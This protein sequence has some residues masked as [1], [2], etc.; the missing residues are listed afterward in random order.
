MLLRM[1]EAK[2]K[3][4]R[5]CPANG[6]TITAAECGGGRNSAIA[7]PVD[8][9]HNPFNPDNHA[10]QF[11]PIEEKVFGHL[12]RKLAAGLTPSQMREA[13]ALAGSGN[14]LAL[15]AFQTWR[16]HGA[17]RLEGWMAD[18]FHRD[19]KNDERVLLECLTTMRPSLLEFREVLDGI[20]CMA[21]D[22]LE[23]GE[24][25][26]LIDVSMAARACRYDVGLGWT[27]DVPGGR[28]LCGG[29]AVPPRIGALAPEEVLRI[30]LD[31][32]DAPAGMPREWILENMTLIA[33]AFRATAVARGQAEL[34]VSD[35]RNFEL[36]F[37]VTDAVSEEIAARLSAH[38]RVFVEGTEDD[39]SSFS[40]CLLAEGMDRDRDLESE[41]IGDLSLDSGFLSVLCQG[42]TR[43]D[44]VRSLLRSMALPLGPEE[45]SIGES[46]ENVPAGDFDR[47][48]VPPAL[49]EN[50]MPIDR[51]V[52]VRLREDA[53]FP[54][55]DLGWAY[56]GF[57]DKP[58]E[59][60][61]GRT[62]REAASDPALRPRLVRL[63]KNLVCA[64]DRLRRSGGVDFDF[65]GILRE[66]GLDELV[67]PPPPLG[68]AETDDDDERIPLDPP[69]PQRM[70]EGEIL[71]SRVER[72]LGDESL[73]NRVEIR[74]SDV[75]D[76][77]N[78]LSDPLNA[79]EL[80]LLQTST[81]VALAA[82]HP[83]APPGYDP[84]PERMLARFDGWINGGDGEERIA[85]YLD[86]VFAESR[87]PE[88]CDLGMGMMIDM[89]ERQRKKI[90]P[91]KRE[92]LFTALAAAVWEAAHWPPAVT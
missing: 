41:I 68:F 21:V 89:S 29:L 83:E 56:R 32:L 69:S 46:E 3:N 1:G 70:L 90:R 7:C 4:Q 77:F 75:L 6:G 48:L 28:R 27:Y 15:H 11:D 92:A 16:I 85:D 19:W 76:A 82:M 14:A 50:P 62:P 78:D 22:L 81:L 34:G 60:L 9:P 80:E 36:T 73:W 40:A 87:Q 24:P 30:V 67:L 26:R 38:P 18:G 86:R 57:A 35:L 79:T 51:P 84:D 33:D 72:V 61:D 54:G 53:G 88:L 91:K 5:A 17:G 42:E 2:R 59:S 43:A 49:L 31:H 66:I 64:C 71:M 44:A 12:T 55:T 39:G 45:C 47:D 63:A 58:N 10:E 8:C 25:F 37:A 20:S 52:T 65:N 74:I 23:P 13:A